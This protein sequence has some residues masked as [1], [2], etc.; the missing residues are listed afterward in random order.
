[1][2]LHSFFVMSNRCGTFVLVVA[3]LEKRVETR[4]S[5]VLEIVLILVF[6]GIV[7]TLSMEI[8][9]FL[10]RVVLERALDLGA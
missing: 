9:L 7:A 8:V 1:M 2:V 4:L 10:A 5:V 6:L 3:L